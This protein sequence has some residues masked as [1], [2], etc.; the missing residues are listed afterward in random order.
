MFLRLK[1]L[2]VS[3]LHTNWDIAYLEQ[4]VAQKMVP[5]S[6]RWEVSPQKGETDL[7]G[8]FTYFNDKGISFLQFLLGKKHDK[9]KSPN[10][11]VGLVREK[12]SSLRD[13]EVYKQKPD[14]LKLFLAKEDS[15]Q[16]IKKKK[17][18]NRDLADY[19][20]KVVFRW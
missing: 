6:L 2:L 4:Y 7:E 14:Q 19:S 18:Y 8:W 17:K 3:E 10:N 15:E 1:N 12:L 11:E 5:R 20:N 13:H 16:K 9:L